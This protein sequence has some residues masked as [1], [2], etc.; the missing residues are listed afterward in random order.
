MME[1]HDIPNDYSHENSFVGNVGEQWE[2]F[3][4][5]EGTETGIVPVDISDI[6]KGTILEWFE[7]KFKLEPHYFVN[8]TKYGENLLYFNHNFEKCLITEKEHPQV[9]SFIKISSSNIS[10]LCSYKGCDGRKN[11]IK[12]YADEYPAILKEYYFNK[13]SQEL[14]DMAGMLINL[15][16]DAG[17][18][19]TS[20]N[21]ESS[22]FE[23][24]PSP[25]CKFTTN[26][27]SEM[28]HFIDRRGLGIETSIGKLMLPVEIPDPLVHHMTMNIGNINIFNT[29]TAEEICSDISLPI[30]IFD[31]AKEV[32]LW[33]TALTSCCNSDIAEIFCYQ[34]T[35]VIWSENSNFWICVNGL[36]SRDKTE[37]RVKLMIRRKITGTI[38][39][40]KTK[41][42]P[43][44]NAMKDFYTSLGK[45]YHAVN[46]TSFL[47][48]IC[49]QVSSLLLCEDIDIKMDAN[50]SL[51]PFINGVFNMKTKVF[52]EH[53][54]NNYI[55]ITT[56][57]NFN[58]SITADEALEFMKDVLP[59]EDLDVITQLK[60]NVNIY[61]SII[62]GEN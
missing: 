21:Y 45:I 56:G 1:Q 53:D 50:K 25:L 4:I 30:N 10:Y 18:N 17:V 19:T 32:E 49:E 60:Q 16:S 36:W 13:T 6:L 54:R 35:N 46:T 47:N 42:P 37:K 40:I 33:N 44:T 20:F 26:P 24:P 41:L 12:I 55:S 22:R 3:D 62:S 23:A 48:A 59:T 28:V 9:C 39:K 29:G 11:P 34:E 14:T 43:K 58:P 7:L 61:E 57:T 2:M 8:I 31:G 27:P 38:Q 5:C 52:S 15:N 51:Y